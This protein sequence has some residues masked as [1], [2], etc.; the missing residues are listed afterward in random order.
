MVGHE[1]EG[2]CSTYYNTACLA[3]T[4]CFR[5]W[6]GMLQVTEAI[7]P[8]NLQPQLGL[9][10]KVILRGQNFTAGPREIRHFPVC[11]LVPR[12]FKDNS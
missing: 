6:V 10:C 4:A 8:C 3:G 7:S 9:Q 5:A 12:C 2:C 1:E 11:F